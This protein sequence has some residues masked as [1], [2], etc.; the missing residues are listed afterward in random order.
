MIESFR[1][2]GCGTE[3]ARWAL[4]CPACGGLVH[5][6]ELRTLAQNAE[7]LAIDGKRAEARD[8][9]SR[10]LNLLPLGSAQHQQVSKRVAELTHQIAETPEAAET[11][12]ESTAWWKRGA[13]GGLAVAGL[14]LG[15]L[16]FLGLGL[17]KMQTLFSML[18]FAG[19]YWTTYGWPLA[20]GLVVSIYIHEMGHV[21]ELRRHGVAANAPLFVPGVGAFVLLK[22]HIDDPIV[23]ARIGLAGPLWGLGAGASAFA[24]SVL[25][26][27]PTWGAIAELTG[28]VNLFNLIPIWQLDGSRGFHALSNIQRMTIVAASALA[29]A[30]TGQKLLILLGLVAAFRAFQA[31]TTADSRAFATFVG[32]IAA[33]SWLARSVGAPAS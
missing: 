1:C 4:A 27:S 22:Q 14:L 19:V 16:K 13:A 29:F 5:A 26:G 17:M 24:I 33:L 32:L 15:K 2:A 25:T 10:A 8:A 9:W 21:S 7:T 31:T 12:G 20:C 11:P 23:D 6:G 30:A 28:F 18:A 3:L